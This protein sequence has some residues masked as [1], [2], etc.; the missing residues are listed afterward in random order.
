M[1]AVLEEIGNLRDEFQSLERRL[2]NI[3]QISLITKKRFLDVR[4]FALY[5]G[6]TEMAVRGMIHKEQ[7]SVSKRF[8][9]VFIDREEYEKA[10]EKSLRQATHLPEVEA[11]RESCA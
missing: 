10:I 9:K 7:V 3:C 6:R 5:T 2:T 11:I 1:D 4:E 8:G